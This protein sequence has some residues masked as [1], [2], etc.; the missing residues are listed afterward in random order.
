MYQTHN[1]CTTPFSPA[2]T[3]HK[4]Y[5]YELAKCK[6]QTGVREPLRGCHGDACRFFLCCSVPK[7]KL[8]HG[9][10]TAVS[11]KGNFAMA[12]L[13]SQVFLSFSFVA[14]VFFF[15]KFF[16]EIF[17]FVFFSEFFSEFCNNYSMNYSINVFTKRNETVVKGCLPTIER[18]ICRCHNNQAI[19]QSICALSLSF[20][21]LCTPLSAMEKL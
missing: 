7:R 5:I 6:V 20:F 13:F 15:R 17:H 4:I 19:K 21:L 16:N 14:A 8:R 1:S 10:N 9:N 18:S 11:Q 3:N 12:T 2:S